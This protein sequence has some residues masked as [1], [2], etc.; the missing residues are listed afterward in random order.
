[1]LNQRITETVISDILAKPSVQRTNREWYILGYYGEAVKQ[2]QKDEM[3]HGVECKL[4]PA[5]IKRH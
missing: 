3:I 5:E 2:R 1:V 4:R